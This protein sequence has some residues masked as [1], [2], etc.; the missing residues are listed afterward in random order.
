MLGVYS[1]C[2]LGHRVLIIIIALKGI[3]GGGGVISLNT[4]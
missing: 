2:A 1:M 3:S 4:S